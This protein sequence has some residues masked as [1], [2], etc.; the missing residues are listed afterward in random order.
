MKKC[1]VINT[2]RR[3]L[4]WACLSL[5]AR[6]RRKNWAQTFNL[7]SPRNE[8]N[9][10]HNY[11]SDHNRGPPSSFSSFRTDCYLSLGCHNSAPSQYITCL[12]WQPDHRFAVGMQGSGQE[13][14]LFMIQQR[15]RA[16]ADAVANWK[17]NENWQVS[18]GNQSNR[19]G[20]Q[21]GNAVEMITW[22]WLQRSFWFSFFRDNGLVC[23]LGL[24]TCIILKGKSTKNRMRFRFSRCL[25]IWWLKGRKSYFL[26]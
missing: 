26:N 14:S 8:I 9:S 18:Q 4:F 11:V 13:N 23:P 17:M 25:L 22:K 16:C 20:F 7:H 10:R 5:R 12:I 6:K 21:Y 3:R 24:T 2:S 1:H 19:I 15:L